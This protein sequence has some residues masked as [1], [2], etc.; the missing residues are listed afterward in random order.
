MISVAAITFDPVT[1]LAE[2]PLR[3][4]H[5]PWLGLTVDQHGTGEITTK[6]QHTKIRDVRI[7]RD[8]QADEIRNH[9]QP[10]KH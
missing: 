8:L 9:E 10:G 2:L 7:P 5:A 3:T 4:T 1:G 6:V